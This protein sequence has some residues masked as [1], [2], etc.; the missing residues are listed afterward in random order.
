MDRY[1]FVP[2]VLG[3]IANGSTF[4]VGVALV[5]R[6]AAVGVALLALVSW[7]GLW[8]LARYFEA[9]AILG[10]ILFQALF[11][12]A[13][14]AIVHTILIRATGIREQPEGEFAILPI[15]ATCCRLLGECLAWFFLALGVGG[16][17]L[18]LLAGPYAQMATRQIPL[19]GLMS[20][21]VGALGA[22]FYL[23][24]GVVAAFGA[25]MFFYLIAESTSLLGA[26][27][28]NTEAVRKVAERYGSPAPLGRL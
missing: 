10:L 27:A 11:V 13:T 1:L 28:R 17:L 26:I 7:I 4:R 8:S 9:A 21:G 2:R 12:V 25:V 15:V 22:V 6:I 20:P 18:I 5:L 24:F 14:Y 19:S 16:A 23:A 3:L